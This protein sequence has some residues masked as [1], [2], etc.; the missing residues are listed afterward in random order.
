MKTIFR[1]FFTL[2]II[3]TI[4]NASAEVR[5]SGYFIARSEC[6]AYRSLRRQTNPGNVST[7]IDQAY[8]LIAKNKESATHYLI[9]MIAAPNQR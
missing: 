3:N 9:K 2:I 1:S 7:K 5:L 4:T 6:P 8:D